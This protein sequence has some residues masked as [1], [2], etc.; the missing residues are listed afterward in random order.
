MKKDSDVP[1]WEKNPPKWAS[2]DKEGNLHSNTVWMKKEKG[3]AIRVPENEVSRYEAR[4]Y[5]RGRK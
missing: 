3:A 5:K 2:K 1:A 4:G